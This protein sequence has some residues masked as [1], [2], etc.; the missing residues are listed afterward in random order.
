M[1]LINSDVRDGHIQILRN[2][3]ISN[4]RGRPRCLNCDIVCHKKQVSR[5]ISKN[6]IRRLSEFSDIP[7]TSREGPI[8]VLNRELNNT[9]D[10]TTPL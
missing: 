4:E 9:W 6:S 3:G 1:L 7:P 8:K 2:S 10:L 5:G